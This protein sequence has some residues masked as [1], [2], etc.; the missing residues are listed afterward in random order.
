MMFSLNRLSIQS[1]MILLLLTVSLLSISSVA[2]VGYTFGKVA[3]TRAVEDQL[4]GMRATKTSTLKTMLEA[5]RDEAISMSDSRIVIEGLKDFRMSFRE[6]GSSRLLPEEE[7]KLENFYK[8]EFIPALQQNVAGQP[9]ADLYLPA[10]PASRYL[11]YH[12]LAANEHPYKKKQALKTAAGDSSAY[13]AAHAKWHPSFA[14]AATIFGFEDILLV[15]IE[16]LDIVYSYQKTSEFATNLETGPYAG[17]QLAA[18]VRLL[19]NSKDRDAY[20]LTDFEAYHP[21][22]GLPMGFV[23]S[24]IFDGPQMIGLLVL[25]LPID[26]FDRVVTGNFNWKEEGLRET[27]ECYLVASDRTMRSRSRFMHSDPA[28]FIKS[29]RDSNI[30]SSV[31]DQ[32]ERQGNVLGLMPV[33]SP[34]VTEALRG[35]SG[36]MET[37]DYRGSAVLSAYG[38]LELNSLRWA[39]IAEMDLDEANAPIREFGKKVMSVST[40]V[41]LLTTLA[42]LI[43]AHVLTRPLRILTEGAR[44]L[45]AGNAEVQVKVR[46]KDEFGELGRV[47]NEMACSIKTQKEKL[48]TQIRENQELLL[49]I[50]PA[51]A[52]AQRL[53]GDEKASRQFNDVSVLFAELTG[54][55]EFGTHAGESKALSVLGDMISALDEAAEKHGIEKVKTIGGSYLA[56]CGLSVHRPDHAR[57][58]IQFAQEM[59]RVM[60]LFNRDHQAKFGITIGINCGPV[61]GGV[62]G[63]RKFLYDLWGDTVAIAKKLAGGRGGVIR[64]TSGV[65]ERMGDQFQFTGPLRVAMDDRDPLEAWLVI[66]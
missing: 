9:V 37:R 50:L 41:A 27:G 15:D 26:N 51:S 33:D 63:R 28:G 32:I 44:Q 55:E 12:Y 3:L 58:V 24:P 36:I 54:I 14:R 62:V 8:N 39:V 38:P 1:K 30:S 46:S 22:L 10:T 49:N 53:E 11:Q 13:G 60:D 31:V 17:T 29:L 45:G 47:F 59:V 2:W 4:R 20:K 16:S 65:R 66:S 43:F 57:R 61:A 18:T 6:L 7:A 5:L 48:A 25:Q 21:S 56:A 23:A 64:V 35:Q 42:A 19:R 34:S 40:G 52:V